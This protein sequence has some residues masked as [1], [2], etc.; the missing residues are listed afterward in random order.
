[1]VEQILLQNGLNLGLHRPNFVSA[2]FECVLQIELP[3]GWK[4]LKFTKFAGDTN[5]SIVKHI[6]WYQIGLVI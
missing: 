3:R 5:D 4:I 2:I 1:M 6:T